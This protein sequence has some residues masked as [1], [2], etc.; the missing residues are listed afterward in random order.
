[1]NTS[2]FKYR[3]KKILLTA[4]LLIITASAQDF[5]KAGT[6]GFVFLQIPVDARTAAL[7]EASI[8]LSDLNSSAI[9]V[10]PAVLG[11]TEQTHSLSASYAPYLADIKHYSTAYSFKS[12]LGVFALGAVI[13]DY[14]SMPK[15]KQLS[16]QRIVEVLGTFEANSMALSFSYSK[17]LTDK[18]SFGLA[19]KYVR[20]K[21][22][23]YSADN[24]VLDGGVI[25]Y[26]G[27]NSLRIAASLQN[28]GVDSKFI[29]DDFKMPTTMRLGFAYEVLGGY[30][31][32]YR[33]TALLEAIHP[34]DND[35][36]I[37]VA[38]E[39]S[40]Q[41]IIDFRFGYKFFYDEETYSAGVGINPQ[42]Q[43]PIIFDFA[44]ADYGRLGD[45]L[46]FSLQLGIL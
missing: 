32:D 35:E 12:D 5:K 27:L 30:D 21:I 28:F 8:A 19:A 36:R 2:D 13:M 42:L 18:F 1:M 20:E 45:I 46:R 4:L 23:I 43:I 41:G 39:I 6:A 24:I 34:T 29:N 44:Y 37:N 22:D 11:F 15:T 10:N 25:Y 14:G 17:R 26:T 31:K 38:T 7:G 9:F 3:M 40:W 16:G 33:V